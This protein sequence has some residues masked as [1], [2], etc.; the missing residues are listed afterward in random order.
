MIVWA[1]LWLGAVLFAAFEQGAC[2][3]DEKQPD[4]DK[5]EAML[6]R[7]RD[8]LEASSSPAHSPWSNALVRFTTEV[9]ARRKR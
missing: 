3:R 8:A 6:P 1:V 5:I 2:G 7:V 9:G 4:M